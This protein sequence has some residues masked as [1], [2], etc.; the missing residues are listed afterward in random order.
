MTPFSRI[1]AMKSFVSGAL[2][3]TFASITRVVGSMC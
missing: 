3:R 1:D 2:V